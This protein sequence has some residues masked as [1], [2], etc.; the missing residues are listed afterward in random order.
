MRNQ[1]GGHRPH[2][3]SELRTANTSETTSATLGIDIG[4]NPVLYTAGADVDLMVSA[5]QSV[6]RDEGGAGARDPTKPFAKF[7][8]A[9]FR[10]P[11]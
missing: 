11:G 4:S 6:G 1:G 10:A 8:I 7:A 2:P 3:P 5:D 9:P